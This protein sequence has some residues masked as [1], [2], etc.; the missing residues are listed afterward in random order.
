[1]F[2]LVFDTKYM[3]STGALGTVYTDTVLGDLYNQILAKNTDKNQIIELGDKF[4]D[5]KDEKQLHDA[6]YDSFITGSIF[7]VL[8]T[9]NN[10]DPYN[11]ENLID[12]AKEK[13]G[14]IIFNMFSLYYFDFAQTRPNGMCKCNHDTFFLG[15]FTSKVLTN[16]LHELFKPAE[17]TIAELIWINN[18]STFVT[19][20]GNSNELIDLTVLK[21]KIVLPESWLLLTL[22]EFEARKNIKVK[23]TDE[24]D[25]SPLKKQ[26]V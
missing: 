7:W 14:N 22:E 24:I 21:E 1:M 16:D 23:D 8:I 20:K 15:G 12:N 9:G 18:E 3:S 5:Y 11:V 4:N 26:K 6:G 13:C 25:E 19:L 17:Y 2:P 10:D